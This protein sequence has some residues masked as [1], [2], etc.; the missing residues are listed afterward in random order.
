MTPRQAIKAKINAV[1]AYRR[2]GMIARG[3]R[4]KALLLRHLKPGDVLTHTICV[5]SIQGTASL[6]GTALGYAGH[7]P[8]I[9]G[10]FPLAPTARWT[11]SRPQA[12][13]IWNAM[14]LRP[15]MS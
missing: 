2:V 5:G 13:Q 6:I 8:A 11:T 1:D 7:A 4:H 9:P 12:S 10:S 14:I 3:D 15:R